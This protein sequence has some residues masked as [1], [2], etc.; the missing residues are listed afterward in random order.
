MNCRQ[1]FGSRRLGVRTRRTRSG[2]SLM[3]F[4]TG[5]GT[6]VGGGGAAVSFS[7]GGFS[8]RLLLLLAGAVEVVRCCDWRVGLKI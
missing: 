3:G 2:G 7:S 1:G 5:G 8:G 4:L 6:M